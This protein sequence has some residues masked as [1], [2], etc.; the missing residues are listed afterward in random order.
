MII[1]TFLFVMFSDRV[2]KTDSCA[3]THNWSVWRQRELW[4]CFKPSNNVVHRELIIC[5]K[6]YIMI[7]LS[8]QI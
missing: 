4:M 2:G 7:K 5:L 8:A 1:I 6:W 3:F